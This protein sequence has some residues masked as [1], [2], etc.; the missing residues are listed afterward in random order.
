MK[1]IRPFA[2]KNLNDDDYYQF[3]ENLVNKFNA[4]DPAW[5]LNAIVNPVKNDFVLMGESFKKSN[6]TLF[7]K[8]VVVLDQVRDRCFKFFTGIAEAFLYDDDHAEKI[9]AANMV[10][11]TVAKYGGKSIATASFTSETALVS[12]L[13]TDL[14]NVVATEVAVLGLTDTVTALKTKNEAFKTY[15]EERSDELT[16]I[17]NIAPMRVLR[18]GFTKNYRNLSADLESAYRHSTGDK[19]TAISNLID[20]IN[21]EIKL[22]E[23]KIPKKRAS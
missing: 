5:E 11:H 4:L 21:T 10:L 16:I 17:S 2:I 23:V 8:Q 13:V 22:F 12:N 7:T 18:P 14:E 3:N 20:S 6:A 1:E 15:Y 19:Q 9:S